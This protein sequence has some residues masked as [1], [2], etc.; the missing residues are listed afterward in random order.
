MPSLTAALRLARG[1]S[2]P[3]Q[4]GEADRLR[5]R[6]AWVCAIAA[7]FWPYSR[8]QSGRGGLFLPAS[9][10]PLSL[11]VGSWAVLLAESLLIALGLCL[12]TSAL[13]ERAPRQAERGPAS[14]APLLLSLAGALVLA[15]VLRTI[16]WDLVPPGLWNDPIWALR[17][18]AEAAGF[19][20]PD[21]A[22]SFFPAKLGFRKDL[23][24]GFHLDVVRA[25]L[26]LAG[27]RGAAYRL[28]SVVP[29]ILIVPATAFLAYRI[30]G[31]RAA[32]AA[33]FLSAVSS[34]NLSMGRW[35]WDQQLMTLLALLALE[36]LA[37]GVARTSPASLAAG[38]G[39][40]GL[41]CHTYIAGW[42]AGLALVAWCALELVRAGR[43]RLAALVGGSFL[44]VIA[45]LA[46][47]YLRNRALLGGRASTVVL[48]GSPQELAA[49]FLANVLDHVG[50]LFFIP[51]PNP[52]HGLTDEGRFGPV[53]LCLF[54][55][56]LA[57]MASRR[58]A[59]GP[60]WRGAGALGAALVA[61]ASLANPVTS[62]NSLRTGTLAPL[63][64]CVAGITLSAIGSD[65]A[66][67]PRRRRLLVGVLCVGT[68]ATECERFAR[69]GL[70]HHGDAGFLGD[71]TAAAAFVAQVGAD[72]VEIEHSALLEG[73]SPEYAVSF[74]ADAR[75]VLQPPPLLRQLPSGAR[76]EDRSPGRWLVTTRRRAG[77]SK[78]VQIGYAPS[79][80]ADLVALPPIGPPGSE[81]NP[82]RADGR[83]GA[84]PGE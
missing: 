21:E 74:L 79:S 47:P 69:W 12:V 72:R 51:D 61:G 5:E 34:W 33:G 8:L 6:E 63:A 84:R 78:T 46:G 54:V 16:W 10:D 67:S 48:R 24:P 53:L 59:I 57:A 14:A 44:L 66:R 36:R 17:A 73:T 1:R 45:P 43:L 9:N 64:C 29:S 25:T 27:D 28:L 20:R 42:L 50:Q 35:N 77:S 38:A 22:A 52:R 31:A 60:G 39:L 75:A 81:R 4:P 82:P 70:P 56:G 68:L 58:Q 30:S 37:H 13:R 83:E 41:A 80:S 3:G 49:S 71:A 18:A 15:I 23:L 76:P 32:A 7:G 26:L 55:A 65:P 19:L 62:P 2:G 11:P 40:A